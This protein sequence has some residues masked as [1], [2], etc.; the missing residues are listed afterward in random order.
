MTSRNYM[1]K[2]AM[3]ALIPMTHLGST[4]QVHVESCGDLRSATVWIEGLRS[5]DMPEGVSGAHLVGS[6][7]AK[8]D[9][10][11]FTV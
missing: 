9:W 11:L 10:N 7:V 8:P 1:Q 4:D 2:A 3:F 5:H 6:H